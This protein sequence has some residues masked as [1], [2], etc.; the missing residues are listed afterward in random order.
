MTLKPSRAATKNPTHSLALAADDLKPGRTIIWCNKV[1]GWKNTYQVESE[2]F[3]GYLGSSDGLTADYPGARK[4]P[5]IILRSPNGSPRTHSL[6]D[7][8][9]VPF[10]SEPESVEWNLMNF[11]VDASAAH[12]LGDI[13]D[14]AMFRQA[15]AI[16]EYPTIYTR[17]PSRKPSLLR[18]IL[19]GWR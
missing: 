1:F 3:T 15:L 8:G 19:C 7:M 2:P 16:L 11:V 6:A 13:R 10:S 9:V 5:V 18:R 17:I 4:M 14:E 12:L